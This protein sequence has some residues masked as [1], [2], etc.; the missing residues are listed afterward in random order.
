[1]S[2]RSEVFL[3]LLVSS[4]ADTFC[5]IA[6]TDFT[7]FHKGSGILWASEGTDEGMVPSHT[8]LAIHSWRPVKG[9]D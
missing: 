5:D 6:V 7:V 3:V 2:G 4:G 1:M 8:E 9:S